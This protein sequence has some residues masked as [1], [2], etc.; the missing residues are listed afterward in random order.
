M[1]VS[2]FNST[3]SISD[4]YNLHYNAFCDSF[5]LSKKE[6]ELS[7]DKEDDELEKLID[8]GFI[9]EQSV[10]EEKILLE[11]YNNIIL[12]NDSFH[13]IVNPTLD[14]NFSCWYCYEEKLKYSKMEGQTLASLKLLISNLTKKYSQIH[15]SF[16]GGE[17]LLYFNNV[18][19]PIYEC[20]ESETKKN[21]SNYTTSFTTNGGLI[22]KKVINYLEHKNV[23][24]MQIT[25]DGDKEHHNQ[26]RFY[27]NR[28]GSYN[29][30]LKNIQRLLNSGISVTAR[31]N[32]TPS[33]IDSIRA[34]ADDLVKL[35]DEETRPLLIVRLHQVWQTTD[36]DLTAEVE[37]IIMYLT[38]KG[39]KALKPLFNNVYRPCYADFQN[40]AL[41]NFNGDVY[42]CTAV[43][44]L[45]ANRDGY[46]TENGVIIWENGSLEKRLTSRFKNEACSKCRIQPIC[47]GG[48][49]QKAL[50]FES[51]SYCVLGFDETKKDQVII[52]RFVASLHN[53]NLE[54]FNHL[55]R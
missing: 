25:I 34:V 49:S 35:V 11:R 16:F 5:L 38:S 26:T 2:K 30:I 21:S 8:N 18:I 29:V 37:Q 53:K 14:C 48:C 52:D 19:I 51:K 40:S 32:Y 33:N 54:K 42:K 43:D 15:I 55:T 28:K 13:L 44:F 3:I 47:N 12:Q 46:L 7:L 24:N 20:V 41:V 6:Y 1:K 50:N 22:S 45:N 27:T 10:D 17:P 9:V 39:V 31:I 23:S 4:K 36:S